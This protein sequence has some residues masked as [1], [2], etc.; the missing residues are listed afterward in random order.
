MKFC[1]LNSVIDEILALV[2]WKS[3]ESRGEYRFLLK[4]A[5]SMWKY[6][7]QLWVSQRLVED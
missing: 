5:S 2:L 7:V 1:G 3:G 6:L 4:V